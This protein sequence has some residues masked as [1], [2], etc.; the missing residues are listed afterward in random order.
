MALKATVSLSSGYHPKSNC[1]MEKMNQTLEKTLQC[2]AVWHPAAWS[3][4]LLWAE[5]LQNSLVSAASRVSAFTDVQSGRHTAEAPGIDEGTIQP[6]FHVSRV[7][8]TT[9]HWCG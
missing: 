7:R 1:Q 2:M 3:T 8:P 6:T 4:Y 9:P 5:Y